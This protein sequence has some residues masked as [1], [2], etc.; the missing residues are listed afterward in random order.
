MMCNCVNIIWSILRW[1]QEY[2]TKFEQGEV[3]DVLYAN[4]T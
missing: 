1:Q 4:I 2:Y 3:D